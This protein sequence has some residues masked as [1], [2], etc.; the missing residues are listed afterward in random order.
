MK[1]LF[2]QEIF[3]T[4]ADRLTYIGLQVVANSS[5]VSPRKYFDQYKLTLIIIIKTLLPQDIILLLIASSTSHADHYLSFKQ[6]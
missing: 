2:S 1:T 4:S 5:N 3:V 6:T